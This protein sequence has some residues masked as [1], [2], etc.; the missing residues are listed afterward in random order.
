MV[1]AP[2]NDRG[3]VQPPLGRPS[4]HDGARRH[5]GAAPGT[6]RTGAAATARRP[7]A[8][9]SNGKLKPPPGQPLKDDAAQRPGSATPGTVR[10]AAAA[11]P[12]P[13]ATAMRPPAKRNKTLK[14]QLKS[15]IAAL[16]RQKRQF[17]QQKEA[18]RR[19][20]EAERQR[21][22]KH[23]EQER[24]REAREE[25]R[26]RR[27]AGAC[28][29][30]LVAGV[31]TRMELEGK[32][33]VHYSVGEAMES[34]L[35]A[36]VAKDRRER[37]EAAERRRRAEQAQWQ[38]WQ[39]Q[40]VSGGGSYAAMPWMTGAAHP[41]VPAAWHPN[42]FHSVPVAHPYAHLGANQFP[43]PAARYHPYHPAVRAAN[44]AAP[45]VARPQNL[46]AK[47][48]AQVAP[49]AAQLVLHPS[50][51]TNPRSPYYKTHHA[52]A[53]RVCITKK[54]IEAS[55]GVVLRCE[56]KITPAPPRTNYAV[57]A[58]VDAS[59][60]TV[61]GDAPLSP[62]DL[63]LRINGAGVGGRRFGEACRAVRASAAGDDGLVRCLLA[64]RGLVAPRAEERGEGG[65]LLARAHRV[66]LG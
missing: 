37:R 29:D 39:Q 31:Q 22:L 12:S 33:G 55:F 52:E 15:Q 32:T 47:P 5:G 21:R 63:V 23:L 65:R 41:A 13:A 8:K 27:E 60:A 4:K 56:S 50:P 19:R 35:G 34:L 9:T 51:T 62:G 1:R 53:T 16:H 11:T 36:V 28:L 42:G 59:R 17:L 18:E 61:E 46:P 40:Q 24:L 7:P 26:R 6:V 57:L 49:A 48:A 45:L 66:H 3:K 20:E 30:K 64:G 25:E 54:T 38:R 2:G 14:S 44:Q 10:T 43:W 58:V